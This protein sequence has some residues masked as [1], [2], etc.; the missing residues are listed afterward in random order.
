MSEIQRIFLVGL[1]GS[2][3]AML[4]YFVSRLFV[5]FEISSNFPS[6]TL[7]VNLAGCFLIG[8]LSSIFPSIDSNQL[9]RLFLLTGILG[10]FTTFSAFS[11]ETVELIRSGATLAAA[12]YIISSVVIGLVAVV[13]GIS[14]ADLLK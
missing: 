7:L 3:G 1:G 8:F 2:V 11:I 14:F 6:H 13:A 4:R 12:I 5:A 10:G 9:T